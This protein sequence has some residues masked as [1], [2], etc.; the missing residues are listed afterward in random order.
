MPLIIRSNGQL[1]D[2]EPDIYYYR[3]DN[4]TGSAWPGE[5]MV[6]LGDDETIA[7]RYLYTIIKYSSAK[8]TLELRDDCVKISIPDIFANVR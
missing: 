8:S 4:D 3:N 6:K 7:N 2:S 5:A 1:Y